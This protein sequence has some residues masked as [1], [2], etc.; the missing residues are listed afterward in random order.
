MYGSVYDLKAFYNGK[1]GRVVRRVLQAR[2]CNFWADV[3]GMHIL[4]GGYAIPFLRTFRKDAERLFA[5]MPAGQGAHQWPLDDLNLVTLCEESEL[6]FE[7][8]SMDRILL[9]HSWEFSEV[10][11]ATLDEI[12]RV[13]KPNGRLLVV[14]ANRSGFWARTDWSPFG[15]GTPYSMGQICFKLRE[16]MFIY[17]RS[18]EA[19]FLPPI[20]FSLALKSA[21]LFESVGRYAFPFVAGVHIVEASKQLYANVDRSAGSKVRLRGRPLIPRPTP[22][23]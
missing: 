17:E 2:I 4:G 11:N 3:K 7:N 21:G 10:L 6:P 18:E 14:V 9:V 22:Y 13:L 1:V 20:K 19:L 15:H 12:W 16:N 8:S 23:A 5:M